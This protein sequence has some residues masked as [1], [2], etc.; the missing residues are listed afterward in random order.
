MAERLEMGVGERGERGGDEDAK[1]QS[2]R[3]EMSSEL[4]TKMADGTSLKPKNSEIA[5]SLARFLL[6]FRIFYCLK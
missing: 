4:L 1:V 3:E 5:S 6:G 2:R